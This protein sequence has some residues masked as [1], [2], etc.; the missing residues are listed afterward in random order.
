[1]EALRSR[2]LRSRV[3]RRRRSLCTAA[4]GAVAALSLTACGVLPGTGEARELSTLSS[5]ALVDLSPIA[6][7]FNQWG[8]DHLLLETMADDLLH[9]RI[10]EELAAE[11]TSFDVVAVEG[12]WLAEFGEHLTP[13][14]RLYTPEVREDLLPGA[15]EEAEVDGDFVGMPVSVDSDVLY[16]RTDLF[17]D[18]SEQAA[19]EERY[20]YPLSPPGNWEQYRDVAEFFTRDIDGDG[21]LDLYGTDLKGGVETDWLAAVSQAGAAALVVDGNGVVV[22]DAAH[23]AALDFYAGLR[24]FAP[25]FAPTLDAAGARIL[26]LQGSLAMMRFSGS[27]YPDMPQNSPVTG[28]VGVA[29]MIAGP[30]GVAGV[31]RSVYLAVPEGSRNR[32]T[33][34]DFLRHAFEHDGLLVGA[35]PR[36][37]AR[38]SV[39]EAYADREGFEHYA[40]LLTTLSS[41][42][43]RAAPAIPRWRQIADTVLL[44]VIQSALEGNRDTQALL[45]QAKAQIEAILAQP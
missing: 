21:Q 23:V 43:S 32:G 28:K 16:Y 6:E 22:N 31:P 45:D 40:A 8:P 36:L 13:L 2:Q 27:A 7:S 14:D 15:L 42:A 19:F 24:R 37:P 18:G 17:E 4:A 30:G 44:P 29:P 1:M 38:I 10:R 3:R 25:P 34:I 35:P 26:F 33:G 11:S 41:P 39:V 12:S 9:E 5:Q 20:G